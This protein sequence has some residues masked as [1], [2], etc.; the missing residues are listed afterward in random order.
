MEEK[1]IKELRSDVLKYLILS[2]VSGIALYFISR[3]GGNFIADRD[4]GIITD[5]VLL[6][7]ILS[8]I[9]V[10]ISGALAICLLVGVF[11]LG[12]SLQYKNMDEE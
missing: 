9:G 5:I 4:P 8:R 6:T 11:Y 12:S 3:L 1:E 7:S 10:Y 2:I